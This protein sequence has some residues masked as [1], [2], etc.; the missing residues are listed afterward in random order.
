MEFGEQ[1]LSIQKQLNYHLT[2]K[3]KLRF[4]IFKELKKNQNLSYVDILVS[5][6]KKLKELLS[7]AF[8]SVPYYKR[9]FNEFSIENKK[10]ENDVFS[11]V[12]E[13]PVLLRENIQT[14][15]HSLHSLD[16]QKR[17]PFKESSG[18]S[19]GTP[20]FLTQDESFYENSEANFFQLKQWRN[21]D[22]FDSVIKIWGAERDTFHGKKNWWSY[23]K[24]F[25]RNR[26]ILNSF[27][28]TSENIAKYINYINKHQPKLIES[29]TNSIYEIAKYAIENDISI[30]NQHAIQ[31]GAGTLYDFMRETIE[32]VFHCKV[33]NHYG[34]REVSSIAS[35]CSAHNGLHLLMGHT[36]TEIVDENDKPCPPG[37][38]GRILVTTLNNYSMPLIRYDIGDIGILK[39]YEP[40]KC[41]CNYPKLD[42][43]IG[44]KA[45]IIK[46]EKGTIVPEYF[47]HLIGVSYNDGSIESFQVIQ[48]H[49]NHIQIK[50]VKNGEVKKSLIDGIIDKIKL[51]MSE[52]CVVDFDFVSS[53]PKTVTGKIKYVI[54]ELD[55]E[56]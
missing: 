38:E 39:K 47:I 32:E 21:L 15:F 41:G 1:M 49:I 33:F 11:F 20:V 44:R 43:V 13:F 54:S 52:D 19:Q 48:K 51:V 23:T 42:K 5:Q 35:E 24:D 46:S 45:E 27:I 34:G 18:G 8:T 6:E 26:L 25:L 31:T 9:I 37:K 28:L 53:I 36:F 3:K 14:E 7:H 17:K 4:K 30:K 16:Y 40:C 12:Q 10:W 2:N 29:Y 50:V 22:P 56:Q 55:D